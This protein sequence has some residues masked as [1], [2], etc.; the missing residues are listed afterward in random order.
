MSFARFIHLVE[1]EAGLSAA[2]VGVAM[3]E[4]AVRARVR[5]CALEDVDSYWARI[6][7][8]RE[9]VQKLVEAIVVPE[10]WFFRDTEA[11]RAIAGLAGKWLSAY[12]DQALRLLSLPCST[13]EEPYSI[14]MALIDAGLSA[15]RFSIDA[16]DISSRALAAARSGIY[17]G[18]SF[19]GTDLAFRDR[20]F[21][22]AEPGW[23]ISETVR[24]TVRFVQGNMLAADLV[25]SREPYD[26]V[27]CRNLLI[28][29]SAETQKRAI[30][31]LERLLTPEG[32]L[33]IGH[34][35]T[36][37]VH[38]HGFSPA[39]IPMAFAFRKA[40]I[41]PKPTTKATVAR[42]A[43]RP[44]AAV[45]SPAPPAIPLASRPTREAKPSNPAPDLD[46]LHR[47][48]DRG[49][50]AE[51]ALGCEHHMRARGVSPEA[52]L[53]LG[54][55]KDAAGD[56]SAAAHYYRKTLYL[57]PDHGEALRH[58]SLLLKKQGNVSGAKVLNDRMRRLNEMR[59]G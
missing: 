12:P 5:A 58:L 46:E 51:A 25:E 44:M 33:F 31:V 28:Y 30:A 8:S 1:Q 15:D 17:G 39:R 45:A 29:F 41:P 19:R 22:R 52:L 4:G 47:I 49:R 35:E 27:L 3:I 59:A 40:G 43:F 16:I 57:K 54:L 9:E 50:L 37:V 23:R 6:G 13:G 21:E 38:G 55:I 14:A 34:S 7:Q 32:L 56:A 11:F 24:S 10:T 36:G 2:S 26:V 53:L 48:A 18:N 20:H 42:P